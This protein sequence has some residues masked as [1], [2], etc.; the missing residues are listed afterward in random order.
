MAS[1]TAPA[2]IRRIPANGHLLV[3]WN[4]ENDEEIRRGLIRLRISAAISRNGGDIWEFHQNIES[5]LEGTCVE[6]G[7]I[8]PTFPEGMFDDHYRPGLERDR[9]YIAP[10]PKEMGRW[11]YPS[12]LVLEDRVLVAHTYS[13]YDNP[14][15][16]PGGHSRLKVLPLS[17][18]YGGADPLAENIRTNIIL[19][20]VWK[21]AE[22]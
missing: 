21:A 4:Q 15:K 2:Q 11:S 22:P 9:R 10:L 1:S 17:W 14:K 3:V 13:I 7:P 18:F 16:F 6:P 19:D 20:K 12:V 5:M 8:R